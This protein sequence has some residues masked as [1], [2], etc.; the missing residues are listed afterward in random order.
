[1]LARAIHQA[2]ERFVLDEQLQNAEQVIFALAQAVDSKDATTAEHL[3]R[4]AYYSNL[5]GQALGLNQH[6]LRLLQYGA[7]LHDIGKV[8]ISE[9]LLRKQGPLDE[10]EWA[11]IRQHPV[12]G[13]RLCNDMRY[14]RDVCPIIRHHHERWDGLGYT[15]ALAGEMIPILARVIGVVDAYDAMTSHRPYRMALPEEEAQSRLV[16]GAGTQWDPYVVQ[17]F[18]TVLRTGVAQ[19]HALTPSAVQMP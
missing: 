16:Q 4:L 6:E 8:A 17:R 7:M 2:L 12:V 11:A 14:A 9:S 13:E 10:Y 5:L 19:E 15:D 1:V 3:P 18:I